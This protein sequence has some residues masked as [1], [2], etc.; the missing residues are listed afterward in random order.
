MSTAAKNKNNSKHK[1][2]T[3]KIRKVHWHSKP[4]DISHTNKP[5]QNEAEA[6][7]CRVCKF[8]NN[9]MY[10]IPGMTVWW[11]SVE[12]MKYKLENPLDKICLSVQEN[13]GGRCISYY[14]ANSI[15]PGRG[16]F[17]I[18]MFMLGG[19]TWSPSH[20]SIYIYMCVSPCGVELGTL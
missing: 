17:F 10:A 16:C 7:W 4:E 1:R 14:T 8:L 13:T 20:I 11:S 9:G 19:K 18:A 2:T 6:K 15:T 3:I 5:D 12:W